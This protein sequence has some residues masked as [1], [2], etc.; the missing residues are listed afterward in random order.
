MASSNSGPTRHTG[1]TMGA[2][3]MSKRKRF[4]VMAALTV[5]QSCLGLA[6]AQQAPA[7]ALA[8]R[9]WIVNGVQPDQVTGIELASHAP[10]PMWLRVLRLSDPEATQ[11]ECCWRAA[12]PAEAGVWGQRGSEMAELTEARRL[13]TSPG[14]SQQPFVGVAVADGDAYVRRQS[15]QTIE[16]AWR[17]KPQT[18]QIR[19]CVAQ[20]G[21]RIQI[22]QAGASEDYYIPLG[23]DVEVP[24]QHR[25]TQDT[26]QAK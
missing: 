6:H 20:E 17:H 25:C 7:K 1:Q 24:Q 10:G 4:I 26:S 9:V 3:I 18:V 11:L 8:P 12:E 23:M 15:A 19:H 22:K 21:M 14:A 2:D 13:L 16:V 5:V